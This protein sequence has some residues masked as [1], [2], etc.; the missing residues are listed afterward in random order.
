MLGTIRNMVSWYPASTLTD[1]DSLPLTSSKT[2]CAWVH[3]RES[4]ILRVVL[5]EITFMSVNHINTDRV[6]HS[7][8]LFVLWVRFWIQT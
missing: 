6:S 2:G 8:P 4:L 1:A 5:L 3:Y 7:V